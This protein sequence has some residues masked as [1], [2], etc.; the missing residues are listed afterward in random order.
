MLS[1]RATLH[2]GIIQSWR[3][4]P[5]VKFLIQ[6]EMKDSNKKFC[7][8]KSIKLSNP[9]KGLI[10][11]IY[12][13]SP[14]QQKIFYAVIALTTKYVDKFCILFSEKYFFSQLNK[15][16]MLVLSYLASIKSTYFIC[17]V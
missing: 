3:P 6:N 13:Y 2:T 9:K 4:L 16:I 14:R 5:V 10:L 8:E 1:C 17:K 11:E 12:F 15:I 7:R